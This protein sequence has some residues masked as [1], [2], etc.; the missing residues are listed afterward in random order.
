VQVSLSSTCSW[1]QSLGDDLD[2][3]AAAGTGDESAFVGEMATP[4]YG[5]VRYLKPALAMSE[6]ESRWDLPTVAHG[7]HE[8]VW[9]AR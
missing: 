7:T 4:D 8:P 3:A 5:R 6:T 2:P 1:Y 9:L